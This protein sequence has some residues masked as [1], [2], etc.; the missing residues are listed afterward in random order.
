[1]VDLAHDTITAYLGAR[2][3]TRERLNAWLADDPSSVLGHCLDGYLH[4]TAS[5]QESVAKAR[6]AVANART[7]GA[8]TQRNRT[9]LRHIA[10]LEAW[11]DG[12]MHAAAAAWTAILRE[13]PRDIVAIRVSQFVL[14][15]LGETAR[16]GETIEQVLP[17]WDESAPEYGFLLGCHAYAL[18]ENGDYTRAEEQGRRAVALNPGDIWAA[19]A[20]AHVREMQCR[21][22]DGVEW[23]T[24]LADRW[25]ECSNF[26]M[27]LRWHEALYELELERYPRVLELYDREVWPHPSDEYLDLTNSA[28]LLWRLEQAG[29]EVGSRWRELATSTQKRVG[30]HT[31]VFADVH[32]AMTLAAAKDDA[33]L[34]ALLES[35]ARFAA[36]GTG[37]EASVMQ[38]VGLPLMQAVVAHRRQ[39]FG[40]V[41]DLLLPVRHEIRL[42][43]GSHA[44]RDVFAQLLIDAAWR[45]G[46]HE[47]AG[48]L[49]HERITRRPDNRWGWKHYGLVLEA[50]G[51]PERA[52]ARAEWDRLRM[53]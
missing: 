23:I 9:D 47:V 29:I 35:S 11:S 10:A 7:A 30:D 39:A 52:A 21:L 49:L 36:T 20:V 53:L 5:R 32:Y 45:A 34:D 2:A 27:H 40:Q 13:D 31:L 51:A 28:S 4:M 18:E 25:R 42:I 24:S 48:M 41:V 22:R 50:T 26:A 16:M 15:Y 6:H 37:T 19:H 14:S 38:L 46:R 12:D 1:M 8:R 44:Q 3:D 17:H 43:G 33:A